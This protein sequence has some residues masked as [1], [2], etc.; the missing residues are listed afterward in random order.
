[1]DLFQSAP[2]ADHVRKLV[3]HHHVVGLAIALI[4]DDEIDSLA[5]GHAS[6]ESS[7]PFPADSIIPVGSL[8]KS[9]TAAAV[10]QVVSDN[11]KYPDVKYD[12]PVTKIIPED[13][14]IQGGEH[15]DIA[16]VHILNHRT[17]MPS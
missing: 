16:L 11:V 9:L 6:A 15:D 13:F 2:F 17:G 8:S 4:Q 10:A 7:T 12:T 14:V 3:E 5:F 1:M